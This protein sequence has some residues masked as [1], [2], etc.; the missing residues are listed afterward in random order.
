MIRQL[1][2]HFLNWLRKALTQLQGKKKSRHHFS[3]TRQLPPKPHQRVATRSQSPILPHQQPAPDSLLEVSP[4]VRPPT[5]LI[6]NPAAN[7][8]ANPSK[9]KI[10]LSNYQYSPNSAIQ[11]LSHQL[12]NPNH[13]KSSFN[14]NLKSK[15]A[16]EKP[17]TL[18]Q[19]SDHKSCKQFQLSNQTT[20]QQ[21]PIP[22]EQGFQH[23]IADTTH[24]YTGTTPSAMQKNQTL[25]LLNITHQATTKQ[26]P[27]S[28]THSLQPPSS[29]TTHT[30]S[31]IVTKKGVVKLLFKF[32]KNNHH[33]YIAPEDGSKDIIF[34]EKY[35]GNDVFCQLERGI[36]VEVKAHLTEGKAY[37]DQV[38]IL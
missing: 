36:P 9:F 38:R 15:L 34:H 1:I 30:V 25:P 22:P 33:G 7:R 20:E 12:V 6:P 10:L 35:I 31:Q 18:A 17:L 21:T 3:S 2:Q 4:H 24:I 5:K 32:K 13:P 27:K 14:E 29:S 11:N 23:S 28:V 19:T 8:A 16:L 37:A 26:R